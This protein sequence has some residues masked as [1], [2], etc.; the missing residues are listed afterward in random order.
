MAGK[1]DGVSLNRSPLKLPKMHII[2]HRET[3]G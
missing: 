2:S 3:G 1:Q